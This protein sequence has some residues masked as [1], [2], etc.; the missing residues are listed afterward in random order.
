[1]GFQDIFASQILGDDK[2]KAQKPY[3]PY[4]VEIRIATE[5]T[6]RTLFSLQIYK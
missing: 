6:Y 1:M 3:R 4:N 2:S 5:N